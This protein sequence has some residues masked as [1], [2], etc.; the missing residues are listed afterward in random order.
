MSAITRVKKVKPNILSGL[1]G[2]DTNKSYG[3]EKYVGSAN[4]FNSL[5][6]QLDELKTHTRAFFPDIITL[7]GTWDPASGALVLE[8]SDPSLSDESSSYHTHFEAETSKIGY[9]YRDDPDRIQ[10]SG[11]PLNLP[12]HWNG[13]E[14]GCTTNA[15]DQYACRYNNVGSSCI[16]PA[17]LRLWHEPWIYSDY[18]ANTSFVQPWVNIYND[19]TSGLYVEQS[20]HRNRF[21]YGAGADYHELTVPRSWYDRYYI[22][23]VDVEIGIE[24]QMDGVMPLQVNTQR[25]YADTGTTATPAPQTDPDAKSIGYSMQSIPNVLRIGAD[26]QRVNNKSCYFIGADGLRY[27]IDQEKQTQYGWTDYKSLWGTSL[28]DFNQTSGTGVTGWVGGSWYSTVTDSMCHNFK[29]FDLSTLKNGQRIKGVLKFT[30]VPHRFLDLKSDTGSLNYYDMATKML[31]GVVP[32][33]IAN[34]TDAASGNWFN[35]L[36]CGCVWAPGLH[37]IAVRCQEATSTNYGAAGTISAEA[38]EIGRGIASLMNNVL[39]YKVYANTLYQLPN[40]FQVKIHLIHKIVRKVHLWTSARDHENLALYQ[41]NENTTYVPNHLQTIL[42]TAPESY[43][44]EW[45]MGTQEM[46]VFWDLNTNY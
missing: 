43:P 44:A 27:V 33:S 46:G 36:Y 1:Y 19:N 41:L 18:N 2:K 12:V 30:C 4:V 14:V 42:E 7:G 26:I 11:I 45:K 5:R 10:W 8:T 3:D 15:V 16:D 40:N 9:V 34:Q 38:A 37:S 29:D 6:W 28:S 21:V 25:Y 32:V 22:S 31:H 35:G 39:S 13:A 20:T 23:S 17:W 24:I